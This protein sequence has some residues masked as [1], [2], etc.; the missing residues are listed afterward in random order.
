[1]P[2]SKSRRPRTKPAQRST[3][4]STKAPKDLW[5]MQPGGDL[6]SDW[7]HVPAEMDP[8]E[9]ADRATTDNRLST[10][11]VKMMSKVPYLAKIYGTHIPITA[12]ILLDDCIEDGWIGLLRDDGPDTPTPDAA[13]RIPLAELVPAEALDGESIRDCLHGL[14]ASGLLIMDCEGVVALGT[15]WYV[16]DRA[17]RVKAG[18]L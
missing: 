5:A 2:K 1:M 16:K 15:P 13:R 8:Q 14:H 9:W 17:R 11:A 4:S 3:R 12:A 10:D 18:E 7:W 6:Y